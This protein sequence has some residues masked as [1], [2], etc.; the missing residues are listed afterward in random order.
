MAHSLSFLLSSDAEMQRMVS[1]APK[2]VVHVELNVDTSISDRF[3]EI[4]AY[5]AEQANNIAETWV[6]KL[7]NASASVRRVFFDGK[8]NIPHL[9]F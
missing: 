4:D 2:F 5:T 6:N 9:I 8:L 7:G 3:V 1:R